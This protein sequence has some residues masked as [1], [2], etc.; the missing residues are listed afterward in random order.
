MS[1]GQ[2]SFRQMPQR[3][4]GDFGMNKNSVLDRKTKIFAETELGEN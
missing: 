2:V 3:I 1:F 4:S